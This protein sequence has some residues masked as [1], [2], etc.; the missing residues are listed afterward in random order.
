MPK[1]PNECNY[2]RL[3]IIDKSKMAASKMTGWSLKWLHLSYHLTQKSYVL[4]FIVQL[5]QRIQL[6]NHL[7]RRLVVL[8]MDGTSY[9]NWHFRDRL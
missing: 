7:W 6:N 9:L 2:R 3:I 1:N 8:L 4:G 5:M